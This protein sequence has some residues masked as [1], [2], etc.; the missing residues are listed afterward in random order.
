MET[1]PKQGNAFAQLHANTLER[2]IAEQKHSP[3]AKSAAKK[4]K[5]S[6]TNSSVRKR[7]KSKPKQ[8]A[9][10]PEP[11]KS[12]SPSSG[13]TGSGFFVSKLGH[14]VTNEHVVRECGSVTVGDNANK[15]VTASVLE[16]DKRNDLALLRISST[17][18]A[19]AETKSLI[20]KL[21]VQKL[22]L[23]LVP[24]ASGGLMRSDDIELGERVL[25]FWISLR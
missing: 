15:Q 18:M 10:R 13:S 21:N 20:S 4:L 24:L 12:P 22:G 19:S 6:Q 2:R 25:V 1:L 23:K 11:K 17:Q 3:P 14:I 8:I 9:K 16:T 5:T 7:E